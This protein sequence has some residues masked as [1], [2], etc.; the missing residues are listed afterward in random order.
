[1]VARP[2]W[3]SFRLV[4]IIKS[5]TI[6]VSGGVGDAESIRF[7]LEVVVVVVVVVDEDMLLPLDEIDDD[8]E[9]ETP[10]NGS[11]KSV[12]LCEWAW[13]WRIR[14]TRCDSKSFVGG[15]VLAGLVLD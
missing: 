2:F 11:T 12:A 13:L 15:V 9:E 1:M 4:V 8:E 7:K 6:R 10:P 3:P 5:S 14:D